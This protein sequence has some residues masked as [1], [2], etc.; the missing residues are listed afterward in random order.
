MKNLESYVSFTVLLNTTNMSVDYCTNHSYKFSGHVFMVFHMMCHWQSAFAH[1]L[2]II[3]A[4]LQIQ[5]HTLGFIIQNNFYSI[6]DLRVLLQRHPMFKNE[7]MK[8]L[9][10]K[11][12]NLIFF[13]LMRCGAKRKLLAAN[14]FKYGS[15]FCFYAWEHE[16]QF[17]KWILL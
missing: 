11:Y 17:A 10:H 1:I 12:E 9:L 3:R 14:N 6:K 4:Y 5:A 8:S 15:Y 13:L 16:R 2:K 7:S